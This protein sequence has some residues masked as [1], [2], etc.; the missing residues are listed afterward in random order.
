M[1][2]DNRIQEKNNVKT[3]L[4]VGGSLVGIAILA[5]IAISMLFGGTSKENDG[6]QFSTA[7]VSNLVPNNTTTNSTIKT[8]TAS[9][10]IGKS[11]NEMKNETNTVGTTT[12]KKES[13]E[14]TTK[15][16]TTTNTTK[17]TNTTKSDAAKQENSTEER[18]VDETKTEEK[19]EKEKDPV[20]IKPVEGETLREY[21]KDKLVYSET[22][23][24]WITHFG[25]DIKA[26]KTSVVKCAADGRV[27]SIKNDPR[28][29][30]TVVVEHANNFKTVY[31]NLLTA[32]F[33]TE[34]EEITSGQTI[35]TIGN[36]STF[37]VLDADHLHFE[38]LKDNENVDPNIYIP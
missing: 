18:K 21:A 14:S 10:S 31:S 3:I 30:L 34:G 33:V 23:K 38:I 6:S 12:V 29:G 16:N 35:G 24:E 11:V 32:E 5:F 20:F 2:R 28:Y 26:D 15:S 4:Y 36:T 13:A 9:T 8:E 7:K 27:A 25:V 37:E 19:K 17:A 1:R 22:L